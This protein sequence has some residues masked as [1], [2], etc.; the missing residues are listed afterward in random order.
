[1]RGMSMNTRYG[2]GQA[3]AGKIAVPAS[4]THSTDVVEHPELVSQR[5][6]R[7]ARSSSARRT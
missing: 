7:F 2:D 3:A 4:V 1:M 5:I 6:Q